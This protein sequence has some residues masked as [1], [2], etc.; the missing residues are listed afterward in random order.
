M[1]S[2]K[3]KDIFR[4]I[5][6]EGVPVR[7][8][9]DVRKTNTFSQLQEALALGDDNRPLAGKSSQI[10]FTDFSIR[11]MFANLVR[12][13][14]DGQPVGDAF[15][16]EYF[17][18]EDGV[19]R[20]R[21]SG[22]MGAVDYSV[23]MGIT[24]QLLIN[25]VLERF[26]AEEFVFTKL[27]GNYPT[28]MLSGERIPGVSL[29]ADPDP[30]GVEDITIVP[31]GMPYK[32]IGF[33]QEYI[34][35]PATD[36]R[37][38]IIPVTRKAIFGDRTGLVA[39]Q[40]A[41]V[42]YLLGLRKEK[43]GLGCLLGMGP[44]FKE[45]RQFDKTEVT[46]DLYQYASATSGA[47]QQVI[48]YATRDYPFYNDIP[49]NPFTDYTNL[50]T[51][52]QYFAK[53]VDPSTGE[54]IVIGKPFVFLPQ[55]REFD[56]VQVL[57]AMNIWKLS[58]QGVNT[59]GAIFTTG[60]NP[61]TQAKGAVDYRLSRQLRA[62]MVKQ[63]Y[64]GTD[65]GS[66]PDKVWFYGDFERAIKYGENWPITVTQAPSNSEAEFTQ[67]V[68]VRFRASESGNWGIW[69]PRAIQRHNYQSTS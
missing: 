11:D 26:V 57:Q 49:A 5:A 37:G 36:V 16:Q 65:D 4:R 63:L 55:T 43:R 2:F 9:E 18:D 15:V 45:F 28:K 44:S 10:K 14:S 68:V 17:A 33:G 47:G 62:Q 7:C 46:L 41:E 12:T 3:A 53:T 21:E 40:A 60:P 58:Q 64:S 66:T 34:D 8:M 59:A 39:R 23:F 20:L 56:V 38:L 32:T 22:A 13:R 48:T 6:S 25:A 67:D 50:K 31:D 24:G 61:I 19:T 29:P 42:G 27:A 69:E 52:E 30:T 51:A 54:P 35:L 1:A